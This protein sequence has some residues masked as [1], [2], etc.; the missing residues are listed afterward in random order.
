MNNEFIF[1]GTGHIARG[2]LDAMHERNVIPSLIVTAPD[3]P[4][5][6]GHVLSPSL[7]AQWAL[8]H[9]IEVLKPE[10]LDSDFLSSL[11][12]RSSQFAAPIFLV[13]DYGLI[14]PQSLLDI[15][16]LGVLNMH[17]SLL[18]RLRGPSPIRS[19]ILNDEPETGVS[20]ML[21]DSQMDHGPILAQ[22]IIPTSYWP[23]R[24]SEL[25]ILLA[26]AGGEL[27]AEVLPKYLRGE[28][29]PVE[30]DHTKATKCQM[31]TK[32]DGL[33]DLSADPYANLLKIRAFEGWPGTYTY[34]TNQK[35]EMRNQKDTMRI[36]II[37]AEILD[38]KLELLRVV[39]EGKKEMTFQEFL[40]I[41]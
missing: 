27:V 1:F 17:P 5:G 18:P 37:D 10:K 13:I 34:V 33:I 16:P 9:Q 24:G 40:R 26:R 25:D 23:M 36:K 31:F 14:L 2:A 8:D 22:R 28:I 20:V 19:A 41:S 21:L 7:V 4:K 15:P 6:R 39:P 12:A 3:R 38:G 35:S 30:Q 29:T 32:E 11:E